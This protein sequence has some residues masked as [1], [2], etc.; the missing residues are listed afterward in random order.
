[1]DVAYFQT[2]GQNDMELI[3]NDGS[4]HN[5]GYCSPAAA[6][7]HTVDL[8][9][10]AFFM[11]QLA[12]SPRLRTIG[13]DQVIA[14]LIAQAANDLTDLPDGDPRK[15]TGAQAAAVSSAQSYGSGWPFHHHHIHI[16]LDWWSSADQSSGSSDG[17]SQTE[18]GANQSMS[19]PGMPAVQMSTLRPARASLASAPSVPLR[20]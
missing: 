18:S 20:K 14:P 12:A 9:R 1:M 11:A 7:L 10:Q 17:G 3:C 4:V 5:D 2:D 16:S 19:A 13:V 6:E 8:P 15:L